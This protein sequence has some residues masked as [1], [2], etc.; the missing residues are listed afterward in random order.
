MFDNKNIKIYNSLTNQLEQF[1]PLVENEISMYVCGPTVYNHMHIGNARP[2]I[3]FDTVKRFFKY[4][5]YKVTYASNF[6][7]IDDKIIKAAQTEG[8][9]EDVITER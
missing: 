6:T 1:K 9:S 4:I 3:F 2:V 7:D 8:V 5:G